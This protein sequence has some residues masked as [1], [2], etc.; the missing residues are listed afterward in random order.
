LQDTL[1]NAFAGLHIKADRPIELGQFSRFES[2]EEEY[3]ERIGWRS[4][5]IRMLPNKSAVVP[6]S[7]LVQSTIINY[8]LPDSE[9]A[10]LVD[11]GVHY[12]S[13]LKKVERVTCDVARNILQSV[14]GFKPILVMDVWNTL[15]C[16]T[17]NLLNAENMLRRSSQILTGTPF[18]G[19]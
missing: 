8:D 4:T 19:G 9:V 6:N 1:D 12:D 17:T 10:V 16:W 3:V 7:K 14:A 15:I 5:R 18:S 2:G 11:V 13:D